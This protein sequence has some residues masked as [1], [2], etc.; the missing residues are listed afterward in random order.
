MNEFI[1]G[2]A[3]IIVACCQAPQVLEMKGETLLSLRG[4][5]SFG[6]FLLVK[7]ITHHNV[8]LQSRSLLKWMCFSFSLLANSFEIP[9]I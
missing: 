7:V 4:A 9:Q 5:Y 3:F 6:E 2:A 1:A 8:N